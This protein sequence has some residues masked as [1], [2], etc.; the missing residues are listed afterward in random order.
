[1]RLQG[2]PGG[3]R[4]GEGEL[5]EVRVR[6]VAALEA[7]GSRVFAAFGT[8]GFSKVVCNHQ[9]EHHAKSGVCVLLPQKYMQGADKKRLQSAKR[10]EAFAKK[11]V[12][13]LANTIL[14]QLAW[15]HIH[16]HEIPATDPNH[17]GMVVLSW[18]AAVLLW[19]RRRAEALKAGGGAEAPTSGD[20][21]T[22][23]ELIAAK[24]RLR[25]HDDFC[26]ATP[27]KCNSRCFCQ[28]ELRKTRSR[29]CHLWVCYRWS[30]VRNPAQPRQRS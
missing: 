13:C 19:L 6:I 12:A 15:T 2:F 1:M 23:F 16:L 18:S 27:A 7:V 30:G 22:D 10:K 24:R 28:K 4:G 3:S 11:C 5:S 21:E 8:R 25:L 14:Q 20:P 17:H 29:R 9:S 26:P